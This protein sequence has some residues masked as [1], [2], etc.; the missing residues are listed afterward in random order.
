MAVVEKQI[1]KI[2]KHKKNNLFMGIP[3]IIKLKKLSSL[4]KQPL[5]QPFAKGALL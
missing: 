3:L 4:K 2:V 1:Q 5:C